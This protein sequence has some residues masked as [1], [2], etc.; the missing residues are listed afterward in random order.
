MQ[1]NTLL[2]AILD[3][4]GI[5]HAGLAAHVN[6]AGRARGLTLRYE[7]TAVARWLKGQRPRLR[8]VAVATVVNDANEVL[9]LWRHRFITDSWGWEL[10]AGVVEDGEDVAAAAARELEEETGWRPGPLHHLI[11][12]EPSNGL[13]DARHHIYWSHEGEYVGDPVDAFESDRREWVPLKAVPDL[14]TRGEVPAANMAAALLLLHH[15]R[16]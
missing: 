14:I 1:P 2:D 11:S 8:P 6:Q 10:A 9:L 5:S 16:L 3:E 15:L 7:H 12:V 13:T 4:A